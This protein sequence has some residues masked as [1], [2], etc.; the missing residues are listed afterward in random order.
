MNY[1][2]IAPQSMRDQRHEIVA[3]VPEGAAS[4]QLKLMIQ[5]ML[6]DR[7]KLAVHHE[8]K[9]M[10][11]YYLTVAKSGPKLEAS[12]EAPPKNDDTPPPPPGSSRPNLDKDGY[13]VLGPG[14][15]GMIMEKNHARLFFPK[16]TMEQFAKQL[17]AQLRRP[18]TDATGLWTNTTSRSF[19]WMMCW[20]VHQ[21][22]AP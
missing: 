21:H 3:K 6:I 9:E 12:L 20:E 17:G 19:G 11:R 2:L 5:S 4:G 18:V 1:Q 7:F 16:S 13:P 14:R 8:T 22:Q 10:P 15:A